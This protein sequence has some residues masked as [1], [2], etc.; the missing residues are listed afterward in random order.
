[1]ITVVPS[2]D[3]R[4]FLKEATEKYRSQLPGTLAERYLIETRGLTKETLADFSIGYVAEPEIGHQHAS[5]CITFPYLTRTGVTA[6][7][8][9]SVP[10]APKTYFNVHGDHPRIYNAKILATSARKVVICEGEMDTLTAYQA[11]LQAV[12]IPGCTSWNP[13]W[14]RAFRFREVVVLADGDDPG[15]A[16]AKELVKKIEGARYVVLGDGEDVNSFVGQ[17]GPEQLRRRLGVHD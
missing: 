2:D 4:K 16:F 15:E 14:G 13:I 6:I 12:G 1:M 3:T 11:G 5:G 7:R 10:P 17:H 8:F 9:R